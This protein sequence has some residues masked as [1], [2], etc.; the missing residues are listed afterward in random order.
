M[1]N[2]RLK[3][4]TESMFRLCKTAILF[5]GGLAIGATTIGCDDQP[6]AE[7][8]VL[9]VANWGG[10]QVDSKFMR[11]E[12][13]IREGFEHRHPGVRIQFEQIPGE[14]QYASKLLMMHVTGSVPDVVWVDASSAAVFIDNG[15]LRDLTPYV[16]QDPDFDLDGYFESVLNAYR[17]K[18]QLYA[19]PLDF[20]PMML[21]Y[22][23]RL[24]DAAAV[25]YPQPGWT[26]QDFLSAAKQLTIVEH[27]A[28]SPRQFGFLFENWAPKWI[29][30]LW[31]NGGDVLDPTGTRATGHLDS[32]Q[33]VAAVQFLVDLMGK[34]RVAPDPRQTAAAGRDPFR[35][36]QVAMV[37]TGHWM[38]IEYRA[39]GIDYAAVS[40]PSNTGRRET[41]AY[42]SGLGVMTRAR[43]PDLAWE[44]IK[45]MTSTDVQIRR[46]APGLAISGN[47][48]AA[49]YHA[50][51]PV[52]DAFI[53]EVRYARPP[54]GATVERYPFIE[55]LL[56]EM[57]DDI[58]H[59]DGKLPVEQALR[60]TARLIDSA[61]ESQGN[62]GRLPQ[63]PA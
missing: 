51:E 25:P 20:T 2:T 4:G 47:K 60:E 32:P 43:R 57:M 30:W 56:R 15:V 5:A 41:V 63:P 1:Y 14:G 42:A 40:L 23:R 61:L 17:R 12:R 44:Y 11:L 33:S 53:A 27:D 29:M 21:F 35:A 18:D 6:R 62:E 54:W 49:E 28:A 46:V 38:M 7:Q 50:G 22:N 26:W 52:E 10:V 59:S 48:A 45:Y 24:F 3:A 36:G 37:L 9:R 55:D 8:V 13:D 16:R 34:Y 39:D 31:T 58:L 19:I